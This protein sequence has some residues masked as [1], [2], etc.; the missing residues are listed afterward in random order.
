MTAIATAASSG[1]TATS[2]RTGKDD[3]EDAL[4]EQPQFRHLAAVQWDGGKLADVFDGT[5]PRHA[6]VHIGNNPKIHAMDAR[7]I[8]RSLDDAALA[9][10]GKEYFIDKLLASLLKERIQRPNHIAFSRYRSGIGT[11]KL[12]E[13]LER[14]T[15]VPDALHVLT[16]SMRLRPGA[17]YEHVARAQAAVEAPMEHNAIHQPPETHRNS[18][19][20]QRAQDDPAGNVGANQIECAGEQQSGGEAGLCA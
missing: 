7:L 4:E 10:G 19:H 8:Q 17:D 2:A 16:Q 5:V 15:K 6:V 18:H 12:D 9:R 14:V 11:G 3:I 13:T 1:E 20:T